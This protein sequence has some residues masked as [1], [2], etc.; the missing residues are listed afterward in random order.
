MS[1]EGDF[2]RINPDRYRNGDWL[3]SVQGLSIYIAKAEY[4]DEQ[5]D[6]FRCAY[7]STQD[8]RTNIGNHLVS[9]ESDSF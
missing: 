9:T 4:T 5:R 3:A 1:G 6:E 8:V 2:M 7:V